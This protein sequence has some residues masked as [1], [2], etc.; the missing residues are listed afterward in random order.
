MSIVERAADRLRAQAPAPLT[1]PSAAARE[2]QVPP[3]VTTVERALE[4]VS[5]ARS[6]GIG[7]AAASEERG[8]ASVVVSVDVPRFRQMGLQPT[9]GDAERRLADEL[10]RVKRPLLANVLGRGPEP[11][12]R[13]AYVMVASAL[14]GEGK[15]FTTWNLA[16]SMAREPDLE[17]LL[18]DGDIPKADITRALALTGRPGLSEVL[19]DTRL[20]PADVTLT[21]DV[22]NLRVLPAGKYHP[23]TAELLGGQ[24]MDDVLEMLESGG[25]RR[26]VLFDSPPLLTAPEAASLSAHMGQVVVVVAAARTKQQ[27][28]A[29]ALETLA[30]TPYVGFVL[31]MSQMS[32]LDGYYYNYGSYAQRESGT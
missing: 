29:L 25:R 16:R 5:P 20:N 3:V 26:V 23:L 30:H 14:P 11:V 18:V 32:S 27:E 24:R 17:V 31:N 8:S 2:G 12:P 7:D 10:R 21:T 9:D 1:G 19:S 6:T 15:T 28:V 13:S 4:S 22:A